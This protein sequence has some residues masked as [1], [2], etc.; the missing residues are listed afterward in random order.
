MSFMDRVRS[1]ANQ[2]A[3]QA[4]Q[5]MA[6]GQAKLT[7][8]QV[9]RQADALLRDLGAAVYAAQRQ[10]GP[11]E[12]IETAMAALDAHATQHGAVDTAPSGGRHRWPGAE[13]TAGTTGTGTTGTGTGTTGTPGTTDPSGTPGTGATAPDPGPA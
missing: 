3:Q 5:G 8:L 11:H 4:Q 2:L 1:Q 9:R 7:E 6:Q 13:D 12:P 10:G